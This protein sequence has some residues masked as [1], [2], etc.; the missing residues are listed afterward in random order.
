MECGV[1]YKLELIWQD[2]FGLC[3]GIDMF[4]LFFL[5]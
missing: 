1:S 4:N 2:V 3:V 5:G